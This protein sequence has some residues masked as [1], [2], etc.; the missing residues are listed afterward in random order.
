VKAGWT[1]HFLDHTTFILGNK[2]NAGKTAFMNLALSKIREVTNPAFLS[3]GIDGESND[4]IDGR[5]KPNISTLP[6]DIV[7]STIPMIKKSDGAFK[8]LKVFPYHT[9]LGQLA[10]VQTTRGGNIELVGPENNSQLN[11]VIEFLKDEVRCKTIV[12]DGA[13]NRKTPLRSLKNA[14]FF[15]VIN[16]NRRTISKTL[17]TCCFLK[18][19]SSFNIYNPQVDQVSAYHIKGALTNKKLKEIPKECKTIVIDNLSSVF[20]TYKQLLELYYQKVI[21]VKNQFLLKGIVLIS[22]DIDIDDFSNQYHARNINI[23]LIINPYVN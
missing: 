5:S 19:C 11:V 23:E 10:T 9:M 15:Y 4:L 16:V 8:L 12:I 22:K 21:C 18:L 6:N 20:I 1:Y 7:T 3:V 13:A 2:K 17:E 14:S